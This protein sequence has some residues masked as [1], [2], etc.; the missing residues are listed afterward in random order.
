VAVGAGLA[1]GEG[2]F[3]LDAFLV[4]LTAAL[5]VNIGANFANDASDARRGADGP[6]RIGPTRA[7]ASGLISPKAMWSAVLAVFGLASVGGIYLAV[8]SGW[9]VLAIGAASL[10]A[11]LT[12]TGG[13]RPYGYL[14]FGEFAVFLFFGLAA[15]VGSRFVHDATAPAAAWL[16]A[17]PL[18]LTVTAIL[19]AN[20]V[21]DADTDRL[22]GKRTLAVSLGRRGGRYLYSGLMGGAFIAL[23]IEA[24][25]GAVP[26]LCLLG[27]LAAP[28]A[29][30]VVIAIFRETG[31]PAL[32]RALRATARLH[33]LFGALVAFGAAW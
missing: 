10:V 14:G 3:R 22:V 30:P 21:R 16:L 2:V 4:S 25:W 7:V 12:Y 1:W 9:P 15:T 33:A 18:G 28:L 32:I 8:I 17:I 19:V 11:A 31:G 24:A 5:L 29:V 23:A 20:N 13:P 6:A 27:L 26:R